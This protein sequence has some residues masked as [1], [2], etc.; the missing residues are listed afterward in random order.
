[1]TLNLY[2]KLYKEKEK[3]S[4]LVDNFSINKEKIKENNSDA[5]SFSKL[6][7]G[8]NIVISGIENPERGQIRNLATEMGAEYQSKWTNTSTHL[9][10]SIKGTPKYNEVKESGHGYIVRPSWV[11]NCYK[12]KKRLLERYYSLDSKHSSSKKE[13]SSSEEDKTKIK[14]KEIFKIF[15]NNNNSEDRKKDDKDKKETKKIIK[16]PSRRKSSGLLKKSSSKSLSNKDTNPFST[17]SSSSSSSNST[18]QEK[19]KKLKQVSLILFISSIFKNV[20]FYFDDTIKD[21]SKRELERYILGHGGKISSEIND[22]V[23]HY[24]TLKESDEVTK[25]LSLKESVNIIDPTY[26][27]NCHNKNRLL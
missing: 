12:K 25:T 11:Y 7:D 18:V 16:S 20:C 2:E 10:C 24:C 3:N 21:R 19:A 14:T 15:D 1:L 23:T 27:I 6:L 26:I 17:S 9:I 22:K 4:K 13:E 5:I 8:V